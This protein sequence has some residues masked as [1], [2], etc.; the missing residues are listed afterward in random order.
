ME[1]SKGVYRAPG[2]TGPTLDDF[3]QLNRE[4]RFRCNEDEIQAMGKLMGDLTVVYQRVSEMP[5]PSI[6]R[7]VQYPR[8]PGSRP[9]PEDNPHNAWA[10]KCDIAGAL[11]GKLSGKTVAI[12]DNVAVAGVPMRNG[13]KILQ[14]Y[15]PEFDAT[16]IT[17]IL[18]AGGRIVGKT[19]TE[20]L[21]Y[22]GSSVTSCDGPVTN[23]RD[24]TRIAGGSS[25]G[26]AALVAADLVDM[27]T[28]GDQGGSI[29]IPS[30]FT[31][32]V[33]LKP[34]FGLVPYTGIMGLEPSVDHVG[35][36]AAS[37]TDCALLLEVMAGYDEG[38]DS[39]QPP[40]MS[41][42]EYSKLLDVS[43]C[44]K[45]VGLLTEGF[46]LCVEDAV[47]DIVK[48]AAAK[49]TQVGM[50]V[51]DTSIPMHKDGLDMYMVSSGMFGSY[52]CLTR[53]NGVSLF[54][55]GFYPVSLQQ[56]FFRGMTAQ[57]HDV[58]LA[59]KFDAMF[60]EHI[61]R[62]YGNAFYGKGHNLVLEL[63]RQY[64]AALGK[65]DVL[66]L[67]TLPHVAPKL[68]PPDV[69]F[70]A[71]YGNLDS[72]MA[73]VVQF[74]STGHPALSINAGFVTSADGKQLPVGMMIVGKRFDD[75]TVL[76]VARAVEKLRA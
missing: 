37:V 40:N 56:T 28:G 48:K 73:N 53:G 69:S 11:S 15:V 44:G 75:L 54:H 64:D 5:D 68:P 14:N 58:P 50:T 49:L 20:D 42:L 30:S 41:V 17:R 63:C 61:T 46:D 45:K 22:S 24:V 10:W 25:C 2:L 60:T 52:Q 13:T 12:K 72:M 33:G 27:A 62:L 74:N 35:P 1:A 6:G 55:K 57:P 65:V 3:R 51:Q 47:R 18:D 26:S 4:M 66:I 70:E 9:A 8:T 36:M 71:L 34:T 16:I 32:I 38:R 39:R 19:T 29:R 7:I 31:G 43:M 21:C 67:P 59:V 76:Q 23:P